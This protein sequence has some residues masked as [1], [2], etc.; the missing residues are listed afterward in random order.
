ML[1]N[2]PSPTALVAQPLT[3]SLFCLNIYR[4]T[5]FSLRASEAFLFAFNGGQ[6]IFQIVAVPQLGG[7]QTGK[8]F[9]PLSSQPETDTA[10][11]NLLDFISAPLHQVEIFVQISGALRQCGINAM[12]FFNFISHPKNGLDVSGMLWVRLQ[13][14]PQPPDRVVHCV[15]A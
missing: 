5:D 11:P 12:L 15:G 7:P 3:G 8:A 13:L 4:Q 1:L 6:N 9:L 14:A 2:I 10:A